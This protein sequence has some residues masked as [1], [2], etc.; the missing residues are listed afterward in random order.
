MKMLKMKLKKGKKDDSDS[1]V[2]TAE[3]ANLP[4]KV[5]ILP[6]YS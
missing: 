5:V 4:K 3:A 2:E 1:E 6:L